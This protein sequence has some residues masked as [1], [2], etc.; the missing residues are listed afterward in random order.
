MPIHGFLVGFHFYVSKITTQ[1]RCD[2]SHTAPNIEA[3]S[4]M[5]LRLAS[6]SSQA[7]VPLFRLPRSE[8]PA[9]QGFRPLWLGTFF[10]PMVS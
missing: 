2:S 5:A 9:Y 8:S 1:L 7:L 6:T 3:E 10:P 4:L